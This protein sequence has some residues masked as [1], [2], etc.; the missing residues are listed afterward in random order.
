MGSSRRKVR[1]RVSVKV[2]VGVRV[3][4]R[5]GPLAGVV[6]GSWPEAGGGKTTSKGEFRSWKALLSPSPPPQSSPRP[7]LFGLQL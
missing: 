5:D 4:V 3:S 6:V 1:F 7:I 2:M